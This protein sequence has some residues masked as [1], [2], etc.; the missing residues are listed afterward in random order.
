MKTVATQ[1]QNTA[2]R[3]SGRMIP[4]LELAGLRVAILCLLPIIQS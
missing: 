2:F 4:V 3:A 1:F